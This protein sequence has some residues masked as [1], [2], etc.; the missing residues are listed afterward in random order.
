MAWGRRETGEL[1]SLEEGLEDWGP[2]SPRCLFAVGGLG[3]SRG[4]LAGSQL[5]NTKRGL[6]LFLWLEGQV[7]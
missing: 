5:G 1:S 3:L 4:P 7:L 6:E 2:Y